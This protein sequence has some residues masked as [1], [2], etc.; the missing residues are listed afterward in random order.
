MIK[1]NLFPVKRKKKPKPLPSFLLATIAVTVAACLIMGYLVFF[2]TTR[3]SERKATFAKNETTIAELKEKIKAVEDFEKRNANF[4]ERNDIIEQLSKNRSIPARLL[5]ELS[6][7]QPTGIWLQT[8]SVA[9]DSISLDGYGFTNTEIVT[10]VDN[11]KGSKLFTEVYLQES[12]SME[13][14]KIPLYMFKLTLK[15]KV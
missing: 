11:I 7:L 4:K 2:I 5:D 12:K 15:I 14:E 6:S 1:V 13:S 8:L 9:G 3:L 10:Y